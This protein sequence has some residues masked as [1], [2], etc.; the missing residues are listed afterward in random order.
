MDPNP[1]L[2]RDE[3]E[4]DAPDRALRPQSLDE[5]TG[6]AG[7]PFATSRVPVRDRLR[8]QAT[9]GGTSPP[10]E[11]PWCFGAFYEFLKLDDAGTSIEWA[12]PLPQL[13]PLDVLFDEQS[14][15]AFV[16]ARFE[17][18]PEVPPADRPTFHGLVRIDTQTGDHR[19]VLLPNADG[20]DTDIDAA[21]LE[22]W[23]PSGWRVGPEIPPLSGSTGIGI[24]GD[25]RLVLW[26]DL[27]DVEIELDP[28]SLDVLAPAEI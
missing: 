27:D 9:A 8:C 22:D 17:F 24:D 4:E 5:F 19:A 14:P 2:D 23:L 1:L 11:P 6:Q 26:S 3:H 28:T 20:D 15:T 13:R 7:G 18:G 12:V 10:T 16:L 21:F 25:G